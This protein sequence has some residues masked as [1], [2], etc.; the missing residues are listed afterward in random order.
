MPLPVSMTRIEHDVIKIFPKTKVAICNGNSPKSICFQVMRTGG[1][2]TPKLPHFLMPESACS[3]ESACRVSAPCPGWPP[4]VAPILLGPGKV[5]SPWTGLGSK[6][7]GKRVVVLA[8]KLSGA[9]K[10]PTSLA[11]GGWNLS[12]RIWFI[13]RKRPTPFFGSGHLNLN[14]YHGMPVRQIMGCPGV[15][16]KT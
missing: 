15:W 13:H 1:I 3:R 4:S 11:F 16:T 9:E 12:S 10:A 5:A 7:P 14:H 6:N 8:T 2:L